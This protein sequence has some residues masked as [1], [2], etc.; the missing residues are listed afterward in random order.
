VFELAPSVALVA[1]ALAVMLAYAVRVSRHGAARFARVERAGRSPLL[2]APAMHMG[3]WAMTPLARALA[4]AG[5]T[6]NAVSWAS[7][8]L[9]LGAGVALALGRFGAGALFSLASSACDALDGMIARETATAN[10]AGEVLDAA[11]DRYAELVFFGG[12]ALHER[13][14]AGV[15]FLV[16]T[17]AAGAIMV[18][19]ATAKAEALGVDVPRGVMRRPERA[20]YLVLGAA[21]VPFAWFVRTRAQLPEWVDTLPLVAVM[22]LIAIVGNFSAIGRLAALARAARTLPG[23]EPARAVGPGRPADGVALAGNAH[24]ASHR[25]FR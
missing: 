7:L 6:A 11:I 23:V 15:L 8:V 24:G 25:A 12:V 5:V 4:A 10:P 3:Y 9:A 22:A 20:V 19:Y 21:L 16:L 17:A 18:S 2:G 1:L 14:H 13:D